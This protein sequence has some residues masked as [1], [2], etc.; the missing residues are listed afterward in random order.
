MICFSSSFF[1]SSFNGP[2]NSKEGKIRKAGW[3]RLNKIYKSCPMKQNK[4]KK[5]PKKKQQ[6]RGP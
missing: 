6:T 2:S 3:K 4:T 1:K 5:K